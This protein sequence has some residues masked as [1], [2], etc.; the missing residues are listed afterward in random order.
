MDTLMAV[1]G[2]MPR[3][4]DG[5]RETGTA[6]G[7]TPEKSPRSAALEI[8]LAVDLKALKE[9]AQWRNPELKPHV[10]PHQSSAME[11]VDGAASAWVA[12]ERNRAL[13]QELSPGREE[14]HVGLGQAAKIK[15][16]DAWRKFDVYEP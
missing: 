13:G 16:L 2:K 4:T 1:L 3:T 6:A 14:R 11:G 12:E 7:G 5:A 15:E 10:E 8:A 9:H